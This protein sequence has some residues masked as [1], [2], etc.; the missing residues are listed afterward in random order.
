MSEQI[1][2]GE[3]GDRPI[4]I[5]G[6]GSVNVIVPPNFSEQGSNTHG[7]DFKNGNVNLISLQ[8]DQDAPITLN[9]NAK[10]T[11]IYK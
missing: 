10:I 8:I 1:P 11:I 4:I 2:L 5:Q 9:K 3:E 6:G 7:K